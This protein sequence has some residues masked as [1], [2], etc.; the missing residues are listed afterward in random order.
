MFE[1]VFLGAAVVSSLVL[2]ALII[3]FGGQAMCATLIKR[4]VKSEQEARWR[5]ESEADSERWRKEKREWNRKVQLAKCHLV[6]A[7][8]WRD[9]YGKEEF[10]KELYGDTVPQYLWYAFSRLNEGETSEV[11][12]IFWANSYPN[13]GDLEGHSMLRVRNA[14][15]FHAEVKLCSGK[16]LVLEQIGHAQWWEDPAEGFP[17]GVVRFSQEGFCENLPNESSEAA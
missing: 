1:N 11:V 2:V 14:K 10:V 9:S 7:K 3:N 5:R 12:K 13:F 17:V 6:G 15:A 16:V 4:R 8:D